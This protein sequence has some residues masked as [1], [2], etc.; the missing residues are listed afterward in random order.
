MEKERHCHLSLFALATVQPGEI[1]KC[2]PERLTLSKCSLGPV[3]KLFVLLLR[4]VVS[5]LEKSGRTRE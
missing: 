2:L 4:L 1:H 3:A 5:L